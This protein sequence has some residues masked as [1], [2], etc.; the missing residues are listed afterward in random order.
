MKKRILA[1]LLCAVMSLS[2]LAGCGGSSSS[3]DTNG[4]SDGD[5]SAPTGET[6][7]MKMHLSIG[8]TDPVYK[9]AQFFADTVHEKSNGAITVELYPSSS[10]GNTA[11]CLEGLSLGICNIVYEPL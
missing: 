3:A 8:E 4:S 10:L 7:T 6:Y 11:D 9:S 2:L 1:T 5:S